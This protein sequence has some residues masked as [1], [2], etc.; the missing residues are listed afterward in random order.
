LV[1]SSAHKAFEQ[2]PNLVLPCKPPP[3]PQSLPREREKPKEKRD[4]TKQKKKP[5]RFSLNCAPSI[6]LTG[7]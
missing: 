2:R 6:F 1:S 3:S 5:P 7:V 4:P